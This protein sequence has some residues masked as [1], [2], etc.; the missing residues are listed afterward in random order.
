[1]DICSCLEIATL[2]RA[3]INW[4]TLIRN[5]R[6]SSEPAFNCFLW[7][8][9]WTLFGLIWIYFGI[10]WCWKCKLK[11]LLV[12]IHC[13]S[14]CNHIT[15]DL[16]HCGY[17]SSINCTFWLCCREYI[18]CKYDDLLFSW[19]K[20]NIGWLI[21]IPLLKF[22]WANSANNGLRLRSW[23]KIHYWSL[24]DMGRES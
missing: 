9:N 19:H 7:I 15:A 13:A 18:S 3:N 21:L 20:L 12:F 6:C 16:F 2:W 11:Y 5:F 23:N 24:L 14:D 8:S 4:L 22:F 10:F 1:M 17:L